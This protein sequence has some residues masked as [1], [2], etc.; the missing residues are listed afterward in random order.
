VIGAAIGTVL[1][2]RWELRALYI[3]VAILVVF[4][5]VDQL[6]PIDVEEEKHQTGTA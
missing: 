2:A 6:R 1:K 4:I 5:V 3:P